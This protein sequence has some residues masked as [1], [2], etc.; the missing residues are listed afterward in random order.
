VTE[1]L[2]NVARHAAARSCQV[3]LRREGALEVEVTDD[4]RGVPAG[5]PAGV[6]MT[7]MRERASELG[8]MLTVQTLAAGTR[9]SAR[10]PVPDLAAA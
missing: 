5:Q 4:G 9:V 1:A 7:A 6:G 2:T 10:L 3:R 8:G